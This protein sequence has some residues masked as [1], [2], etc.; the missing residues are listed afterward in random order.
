MLLTPHASR[1]ASVLDSIATLVDH[2]LIR[3]DRRGDAEPRFVLLETI[4]EFGIGQLVR[5]RRRAVRAAH[6]R[7]F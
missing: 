6:A 7:H 3:R 1:L 4:R 2:N 5:P